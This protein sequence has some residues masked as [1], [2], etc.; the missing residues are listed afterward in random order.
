M[1]KVHGRGRSGHI[2]GKKGPIQLLG[3]DRQY[4]SCCI[5]SREMKEDKYRAERSDRFELVSIKQAK[6]E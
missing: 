6:D 3:I 4:Y 5:E 1:V 2:L